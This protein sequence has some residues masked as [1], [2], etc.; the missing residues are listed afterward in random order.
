[1]PSQ[2][3]R[4]FA[5]RGPA[6]RVRGSAALS[7]VEMMENITGILLAGGRSSRFSADKALTRWKG[8]ALVEYPAEKLSALFTENFLVVK[9]S[10]KFSSLNLPRFLVVQDL[11]KDFH[12]LGGLCTG[13][14]LMKT[15]FAFV[16]ACDMPCLNL[17]L[18]ETLCL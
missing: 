6:N 14:A 8:K 12:A 17:A 7:L 10:K 4:G 3:A 16:S 5:G 11:Y 15:D 13:L 1:M 18:I 2:C 9:D